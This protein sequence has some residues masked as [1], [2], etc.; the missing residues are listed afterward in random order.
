[1][2]VRRG[3]V[4]AA[5]VGCV[6]LA[7]GGSSAQTGRPAAAAS[8]K[9]VVLLVADQM[10]TDYLDRHG[11]EFTGGF[12]RLMTEGAWFRESAYPYLGTVTCPG[13]ATIGTGAFPYRH[14]FILNEW[15]D[16]Q[17]GAVRGC[18]RDPSVQIV[19]LPSSGDA[20]RG[21]ARPVHRPDPRTAA[22]RQPCR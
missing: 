6:A 17:T 8:P 9:L 5:L 18:T 14:G 22:A 4:A 13:H 10:R 21:S 11:P 1:M 7:L 15:V 3:A 19:P 20:A 2:L 12:R 16:R